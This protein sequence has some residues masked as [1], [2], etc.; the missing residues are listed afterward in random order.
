M[1]ALDRQCAGNGAMS[2]EGNPGALRPV[3]EPRILAFQPLLESVGVFAQI[4][5]KAG[6]RGFV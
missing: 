3:I 5:Q 2:R 1:V 4:V 6:K